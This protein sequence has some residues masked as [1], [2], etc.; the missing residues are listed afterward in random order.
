MTIKKSITINLA[1][2][3]ITIDEDAYEA[4]QKYLGEV[5]RFF[6]P[7]EDSSEIVSD[8]EARIA[9]VL[10]EKT[11]HAHP[12]ISID[13]VNDVVAIMGTPDDF[14][15]ADTGQAHTANSKQ[16][17]SAGSTSKEQRRLFR[18]TDNA[19]IAGVCAG[20]AA[21]TGIDVTFIRI[22]FLILFFI[23]GI[24]FIAYVVF[25]IATPEA[26]TVAE[27]MQ[28]HGE[29]VT[30]ESM[31]ARAEEFAQSE[32]AKRTQKKIETSARQFA[33]SAQEVGKRFGK[34]LEGFFHAVLP[35]LLRVLGSLLIIIT[36]IIAA[37][38]VWIS[39]AI[40]LGLLNAVIPDTLFTAMPLLHQWIFG[41]G[42]AVLFML[43]LF[44]LFMTGIQISTLHNR[45]FLP[46][47]VGVF[48]TVIWWFALCVVVTFCI[49]Y[50][51]P[52][53]QQWRDWETEVEKIS[54]TQ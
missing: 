54:V 30:L 49:K 43:P 27:K 34:D 20:I 32:S 29:P 45:K 41:S 6:G 1:Q 5:E 53:N 14:A 15:G 28:M 2:T 36:V 17:S 47:W 7:T 12:S 19:M 11:T 16:A 4:L 21:Y 9:E 37:S 52:A 33:M 24:G 50:A 26:K 10:K 3:L 31:K 39:I 13:D 40:A 25:W 35:T 44:T 8:I 38:I 46:G 51:E 48:F 18:D 23:N 22:I 42:I